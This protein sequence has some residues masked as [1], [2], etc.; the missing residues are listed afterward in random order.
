MLLNGDVGKS[1]LTEMDKK[2]RAAVDKALKTQNP[3]WNA[4]THPGETEV[5]LIHAS[6]IEGMFCSSYHSRK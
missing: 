1:Q 3:P 4:I 2:V 6:S 5:C